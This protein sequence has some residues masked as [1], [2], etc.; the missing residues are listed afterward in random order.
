MKIGRRG[1]HG[2]IANLDPGDRP[3]RGGHRISGTGIREA[4]RLAG[5]G[6]RTAPRAAAARSHACWNW[7]RATR[8]ART[9]T[10]GRRPTASRCAQPGGAGRGQGHRLRRRPSG[11]PLVPRGAV[12]PG[13]E[14]PAGG[15]G[16][17]PVRAGGTGMSSFARRLTAG[18]KVPR[19]S[20]AQPAGLVRPGAPLVPSGG[21]GY[22]FRF[23]HGLRMTTKPHVWRK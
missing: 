23:T 7:P 8:S 22:H 12:L 1:R 15:D 13:L 10:C 6:R 17:Q 3:G 19:S 2:R 5:P 21:L 18:L 14:L 11:R 4:P 20:R 16:G 9:I